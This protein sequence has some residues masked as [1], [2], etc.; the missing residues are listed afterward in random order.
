M[1]EHFAK[2]SFCLDAVFMAEEFSINIISDV[3]FITKLLV[4]NSIISMSTGCEF[5]TKTNHFTTTMSGC[6][7]CLRNM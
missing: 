5:H 1:I 2:S 6:K 3:M 7:Y 4:P